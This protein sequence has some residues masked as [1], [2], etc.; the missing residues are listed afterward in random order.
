MCFSPPPFEFIYQYS[1]GLC[2]GC[3]EKTWEI[4]YLPT[5][6]IPRAVIKFNR[7]QQDENIATRQIRMVE[8]NHDVLSL[9][10]MYRNLPP[11]SNISTCVDFSS[12]IL[13]FATC[14]ALSCQQMI[15]ASVTCHGN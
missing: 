14:E 3:G 12:S 1:G 4:I 8:L 9:A 6:N 10:K 7:S 5:M 15:T 11:K 2:A 13:L